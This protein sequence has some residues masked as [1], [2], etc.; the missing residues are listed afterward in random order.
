MR[1][2]VYLPPYIKGEE[3][4]GSGF[5]ELEKGTTLAVLFRKLKIPFPR[6]L[7]HLCRVNYERATLDQQLNDGDIVSFYSLIS[8]G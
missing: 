4:E 7:V 2:R 3:L 6:G 8:G 5:I 1:V